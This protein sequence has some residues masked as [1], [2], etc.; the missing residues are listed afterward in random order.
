MKKSLCIA[1]TLFGLMIYAG[2]SI[3]MKNEVK[4]WSDR[5][6]VISGLPAEWQF[7]KLVPAQSC[8]GYSLSLPSGT[9]QALIGL[10]SSTQ[11]RKFAE[12]KGLK[13][14]GKTFNVGSL[15]YDVYIWQNP[16]ETFSFKATNAGVILLTMDDDVPAI[17]NDNSNAMTT[18]KSEKSAGAWHGLE[19]MQ[20]FAGQEYEFAPG[21][22]QVTMYVKEPGNGINSN[23]GFMLML[24]NW[25]GTYSMTVPWCNTLSD[26]YNVIAISVDYLQSGQSK[27][28][29]VPYDHG[30]LQAMDCLRALYQIQEQLKAKGVAFNPRRVYSAG[31]SGGGNVSLMVNK[32]APSTFSCIIDMCGMPGLTDDI[33]FGR[34]KLN[35][36]YS[37]D[38]NSPKYLTLARQE[39]CNPG[40]LPHLEQQQKL[41]PENKVIIVHGQDDDH[42]SVIDKI[43]I[44]QNMI[45]AKFRPEGNFITNADLD[46][47]VLTSSGHPL[48]DRQAIITKYADS[49]LMENGTSPAS[50]KKPTDFETEG[51]T[52]FSVTG[53][54]YV[55]DFSSGQPVLIWN[56]K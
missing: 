14:I 18:I 30:L 16:P 1:L 21:Q 42:C 11:N 26:R 53:G 15:K 24:H 41:N 4:A 43:T 19:Q 56:K 54:S 8:E 12:S 34:G 5:N 46:G 44:F 23:T 37:K 28:D 25:G 55:V 9:K 7:S 17:D 49:Y 10:Y 3:V 2:E 39:I 38:I 50:V 48:G 31:G 27:H 22:R 29:K 13:I 36:G 47:V 40:H 32:L 33:A 35:A 45:K 51:K 20:H 6:Y 52:E